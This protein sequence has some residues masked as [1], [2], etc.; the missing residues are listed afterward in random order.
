MQTSPTAADIRARIEYY[1]LKRYVIAVRVGIHPNNLSGIL[2]ERRPL[3]P[4]LAERLM[5]A[6]D[7]ETR[8]A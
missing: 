6:I 4:A 2:Q 8:S 1:R 5:R 3:T 7:E